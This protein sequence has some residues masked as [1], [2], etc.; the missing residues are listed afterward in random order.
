[1][2]R[3]REKRKVEYTKTKAWIE[4]QDSGWKPTAYS[5]PADMEQ[6]KFD[7]VGLTT[8]DVLPYVVGKN[9]PKADEGK[10]HWER[11]YFVH[12]NMGPEQK[13]SY[14]C[15]AKN[16]EKRCPVCDHLAKLRKT[17]NASEDAIKALRP[18]QRQLFYFRVHQGKGEFTNYL[19]EASYYNGFGEL[20][21]NKLDA[22]PD[23]S[24]MHDFFHLDK[25]GMSLVV[26]SSQDSYNGR[27]FY[28]PTNIEMTPRRH[29][30]PV[31]ILD[32][33]P[34]LDDLIIELSYKELEALFLQE[35]GDSE[36]K[37]K[38]EDTEEDADADEDE[39]DAPKS[40]KAGKKGAKKPAQDEDTEDEDTEDEDDGEDDAPKSKKVSSK[41]KPPVDEDDEDLVVD[42]DDVDDDDLAPPSKKKPPT[43]P[44]KKPLRDTPQEDDEDGE[45]SVLDEDDDAEDFSVTAEDVGIEKG[46]K[47]KHK[48][49]GECVV[50]NVSPD[51]TSL[52]LK[53]KKGDLHKAVAPQDCTVLDDEEEEEEEEPKPKVK[54]P[55]RKP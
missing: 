9:N 45:D 1:M 6:Y 30:V 44:T 39:E 28:P 29:A 40:F 3:D 17:P 11:T 7:K 41:K 55:R 51:G 16:F 24:P 19:Y 26:K 14:A 4:E 53:S 21:V 13:D 20:L 35:S 42:D 5:I 2:A 22:Q 31:E 18:K 48:K 10:V 54:L 37:K 46:S 43:K 33:L 36:A 12:S 27:V 23:D 32:Q 15:L 8:L 49:F 52:I 38:D 34:C 47:V 25:D 50:V